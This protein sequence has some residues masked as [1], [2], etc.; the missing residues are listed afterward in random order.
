M[1]LKLDTIIITLPCQMFLLLGV[2]VIDACC[3][4]CQRT[5][6]VGDSSNVISKLGQGIS[7][8]TSNS[9]ESREHRP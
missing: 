9:E 1:S 2:S 4:W 8:V 6:S 5:K 7:A 3:G